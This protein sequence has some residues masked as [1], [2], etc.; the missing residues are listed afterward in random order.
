MKIIKIN[1]KKQ[2]NGLWGIPLNC[3]E[4]DSYIQLDER[5][6]LIR[7]AALICIDDKFNK[8]FSIFMSSESSLF[9]KIEDVST[10]CLKYSM[11]EVFDDN[12]YEFNDDKEHNNFLRKQK[13][14][15]LCQVI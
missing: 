2:D 3:Y 15:K 9:V 11:Y 4:M 6:E 10:F 12:L 8:R 13:L 7:S 1:R 5:K 14:E